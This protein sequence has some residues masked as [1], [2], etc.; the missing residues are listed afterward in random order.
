MFFCSS[1]QHLVPAHVMHTAVLCRWQLYYEVCVMS[2]WWL[3]FLKLLMFGAQ[4][5]C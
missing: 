1:T 4:H 3:M 5:L 2:A